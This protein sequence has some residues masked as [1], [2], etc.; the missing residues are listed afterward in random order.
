LH[1]VESEMTLYKVPDV[2]VEKREDGTL[3]VFSPLG[4]RVSIV[5]TGV[6]GLFKKY[7][8]NLEGIPDG[9]R[10]ILLDS[11]LVSESEPK[12]SLPEIGEFKPT[13]ATL[14]LTSG[15][16]LR[17]VYC[18]ARAGEQ[19]RDLSMDVAHKTIDFIVRNAVEKRESENKAALEGGNATSSSPERKYMVGLNFHGGGEPTYR[20]EKLVDCVG[21]VKALAAENDLELRIGMTTNGIFSDR[22]I[23]WLIE[24]FSG[25]SLSWDGLPEIQDYNRPLKN[26]NPSSG[27]LEHTAARLVEAK[28][29]FS[30][31]STITRKSTKRMKE[32]VDYFAVRGVKNISLEP[33]FECGRCATSGERAPD[34][35][36]FLSYFLPLVEYGK[37]LDVVVLN[38]MGAINN[39]RLQFCGAAG[40]N[41]CVTPDEYISSCYEVPIKDDPRSDVFFYGRFN[42]ETGSFEVDEEKRKYLYSRSVLNMPGCEKCFM[43]SNCGGGC[44]AKA[45]ALGDL[46]NLK[47]KKSERCQIQQGIGEEKIRLLLEKGKTVKGDE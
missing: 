15:C 16:N 40:S 18:Y 10:N 13:S 45:A 19:V 47:G 4:N 22:Q 37:K 46:Y 34:V 7:S 2:F 29:G 31:R 39:V 14:F 8:S 3:L 26:G 38:S 44:L 41:F 9:E 36:E 1:R 6:L 21:Y 24:N 17:C 33:L 30:V 32:I 27:F 5:T 28:F 42:R 12:A 23:D 25:F 43:R 11:G 20:W 35:E